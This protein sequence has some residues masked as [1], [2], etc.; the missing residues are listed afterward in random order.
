VLLIESGSRDLLEALIPGIYKNH[1][2][3]VVIDV[4]SCFAGDPAGCETNGAPF[5]PASVRTGVELAIPVSVIGVT[6]GNVSIC[7]FLTSDP[8]TNMYNQVLG[9]ITGNSSF[10]QASLGQSSNVDFGAFPGQHYFTIVTPPC[11]FG[12]NPVSTNFSPNGGTGSFSIIV[13][14]GGCS[15]S[16]TSNVPWVTITSATSGSGAGAASA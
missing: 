2:A 4:V 14:G 7:A 15:W 5:G 9:P 16:V 8:Y 6:T 3:D 11:T 1:G 10:C 12:I 13:A